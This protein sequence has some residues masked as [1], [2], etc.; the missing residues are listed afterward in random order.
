MC[1]VVR[2]YCAFVMAAEFYSAYV[3]LVEVD[4]KENAKRK[5]DDYQ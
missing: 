1:F 3:E 2:L 4:R 5:R